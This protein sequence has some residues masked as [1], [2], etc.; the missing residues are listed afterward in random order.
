LPPVQSVFSTQVFDRP[1]D[2]DV[3]L[4]DDEL[5]LPDAQR[6]AS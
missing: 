5:E 6:A 4:A 1:L 2:E 3:E